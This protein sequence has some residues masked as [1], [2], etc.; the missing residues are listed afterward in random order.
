[1]TT[2]PSIWCCARTHTYTLIER[3]PLAATVGRDLGKRLVFALL[4]LASA[5]ANGYRWATHR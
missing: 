1:M 4:F 3:I 5:I 2:K